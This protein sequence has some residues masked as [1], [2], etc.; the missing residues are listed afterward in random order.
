[1]FAEH[2]FL[3]NS[4]HPVRRVE[5]DGNILGSSSR[6]NSIEDIPLQLFTEDIPETLKVVK[7]VQ[8][9]SSRILSYP[10]RSKNRGVLFLVNII[11][12]KD[13]PS[14]YRNGAIVDKHRLISLFKQF[15][16]EIF[17]YEDLTL[18]EFQHL[19]DQL[20]A[21][22]YLRKT[23]CLGEPCGVTSNLSGV[24]GNFNCIFSNFQYFVC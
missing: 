12:I 11:N 17:Y 15:G 18:N 6:R 16:F 21:S 4:T 20:I 24:Y 13:K 7:A 22:K 1:M 8:F 2:Q 23:D 3:R 10:M 19:V 14:L 5:R 9:C